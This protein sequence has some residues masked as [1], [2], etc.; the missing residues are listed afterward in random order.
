LV[1]YRVHNVDIGR[2]VADPL[3]HKTM[4]LSVCNFVL[5]FPFFRRSQKL[6]VPIKA[7][8]SAAVPIVSPHTVNM[9]KARKNGRNFGVERCKGH[10]NA[11]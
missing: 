4:F 11:L 5:S 8:I 1:R 2:Q 9:Q 6:Y 10:R 7:F 3:R